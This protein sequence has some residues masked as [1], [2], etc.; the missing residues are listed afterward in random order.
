MQPLN[1]CPA[2]TLRQINVVLCDIDD[3]LTWQGKLPALAYTAHE[4]LQAT[5]L[6]VVPI[7]G[8]PAVRCG[9]IARM[10]PVNGV[11]GGNGAF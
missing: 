8:R 4:N 2:E 11:V 9:H 7:T 3:T 1:E 6:I 5:K 10:W